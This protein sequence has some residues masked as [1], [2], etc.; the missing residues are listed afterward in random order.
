MCEHIVAKALA[1]DTEPHDT[2]MSELY[3]R[4]KKVVDKLIKYKYYKKCWDMRNFFFLRLIKVRIF[5]AH[6]K[7]LFFL[8]IFAEK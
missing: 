2:T 1:E 8:Y 4:T 3:C 7:N 5:A 6:R